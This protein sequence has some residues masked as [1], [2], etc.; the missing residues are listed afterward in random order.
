MMMLQWNAEE[1]RKVQEEEIQE[2]KSKGKAEEKMTVIHNMLNTTNLS[3][4]K[5]AQI[6]STTVDHVQRI[7]KE[8]NLRH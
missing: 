6:A 3:Y 4:E 8:A 2:A 5:I 7:A 1:A